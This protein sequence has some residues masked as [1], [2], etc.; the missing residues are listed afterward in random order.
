MLVEMSKASPI[1][2]QIRLRRYL[3]AFSLLPQYV[4]V[5][6]ITVIVNVITFWLVFNY[7]KDI[8]ISTLVGNV[9]SAFANFKGL[10][11]VFASESIS[12]LPT[13]TK[14]LI[15]LFVYYW[16]SVWSTLFLIEL[17]LIEV[18]ARAIAIGILL[19]LGYLANRYLV[20]K[21]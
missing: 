13:L 17:G 5:G 20:F 6:V 2:V 11:K 7:S 8:Y 19:P 12:I 4:L 14:Y 10:G 18:V 15:S 3:V 9:V 1:S 21:S 16:L